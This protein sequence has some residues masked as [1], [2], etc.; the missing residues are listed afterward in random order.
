MELIEKFSSCVKEAIQYMNDEKLRMLIIERLTLIMKYTLKLIDL[1]NKNNCEESEESSELKVNISDCMMFIINTFNQYCE[2]NTQKCASCTKPILSEFV[3][4]GDQA[5][6]A[7][8]FLCI[9]C[10]E[11]PSFFYNKDGD[12]YCKNCYDNTFLDKCTRCAAPILPGD[13]FLQVSTSKFHNSCFNCSKCHC[14]LP[15]KGFGFENGE[16]FCQNHSN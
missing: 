9:K 2:N 15:S 6:H 7:D 4:V 12:V 11:R 3:S 13:E 8:C 1:Y 5:F 14:E 10:K 16:V